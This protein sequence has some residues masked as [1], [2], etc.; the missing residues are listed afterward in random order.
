MS[1]F[2]IELGCPEEVTAGKYKGKWIVRGDSGQYLTTDGRWLTEYTTTLYDIFFNNGFEAHV[3]AIN[4]YED[5]YGV[6]YPYMGEYSKLMAHKIASNIKAKQG[7][8]VMEF[9]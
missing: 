6:S 2:V 3:C 9:E 7:S 5:Q 1:G 4:W 8:Q